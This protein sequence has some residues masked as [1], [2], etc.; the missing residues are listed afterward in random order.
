[1]LLNVEEFKSLSDK[2]LLFVWYFAC[3]SSPV[4]DKKEMDRVVE[5]FKLVPEFAVNMKED[6]YESFLS[7]NF[8]SHISYAIKV[9]K[10]F[11][12]DIRFRAKTFTDRIMDNIDYVTRKK[13]E[14]YA[15]ISVGELKSFIDMQINIAKNLPDIVSASEHG[16]GFKK[17]TEK[18]GKKSSTLLEE[19]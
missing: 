17:N 6:V 15:D 13:A 8:P 5:A 3:K 19:M 7:R 18:E 4:C 9:M 16:Y 2:E 1:M 11:D 12:P 14:T 10:R